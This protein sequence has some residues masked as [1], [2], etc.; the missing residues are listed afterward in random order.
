LAAAGLLA[1][2]NVACSKACANWSTLKSARAR[3]NLQA[4]R[5][6]VRVNPAGTEIAGQNVV[7]IQYADFIQAM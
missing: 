6:A 1:P 4:D 3:P 5:Q 2:I 7:V